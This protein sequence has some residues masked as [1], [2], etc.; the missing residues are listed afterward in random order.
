M[1]GYAMIEYDVIRCDRKVGDKIGSDR[2]GEN[3][4]A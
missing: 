4:V 1:K 2:I 3:R